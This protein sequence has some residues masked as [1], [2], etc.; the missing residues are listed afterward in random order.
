MHIHFRRSGGFMGRTTA[1][2]V[3]TDQLLPAEREQLLLLLRQADL[4]NVTS[5]RA[6][7]ARDVAKYD[8]TLAS[9]EGTW[10][11]NVDEMTAPDQM[12]PLLRY[13]SRLA[14]PVAPQ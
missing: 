8:L 7:L 1:Y 12:R 4:H 10:R 6:Q 3:D 5:A 11:V 2:E 13:L 14:Q 9:D